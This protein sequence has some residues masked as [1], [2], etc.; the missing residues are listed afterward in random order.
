MKTIYKIFIAGIVLLFS[1]ALIVSCSSTK[2]KYTAVTDVEEEF[3]IEKSGAQMWG[4]ACNRCHL[5]PSPADYNDTDWE[6]ISLHMRIR[7]NLT[8]K[9]IT[10]I[11]AF[12]KS[13]N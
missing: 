1:G 11:E 12:L 10:K 13:A 3:K 9:E 5:A 4:E 8:E 6:T 7:A 2:D